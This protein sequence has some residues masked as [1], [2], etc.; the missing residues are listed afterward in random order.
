MNRRFL[1]LT[2]LKINDSNF[3]AVNFFHS[4]PHKYTNSASSSIKPFSIAPDF[5]QDFL[6][7]QS[8]IAGISFWFLGA[9]SSTIDSI[10]GSLSVSRVPQDSINTTVSKLFICSSVYIRTAKIS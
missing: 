5:F 7:D 9:Q 2:C 8:H 1:F 10:Y 4:H 6:P 3:K